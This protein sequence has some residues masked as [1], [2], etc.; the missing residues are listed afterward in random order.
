MTQP[1]FNRLT[2]PNKESV[3]HWDEKIVAE[4][5]FASVNDF[6]LFVLWESGFSSASEVLRDINETFD[7]RRI[8][9]MRISTSTRGQF[10]SRFYGT[11]RPDNYAA[12]AKEVGGSRAIAIL[13]TLQ[14]GDE[15]DVFVVA[16]AVK[17]R[18]RAG[19]PNFIHASDE[20]KE[21]LSNYVALGGEADV[22]SRIPQLEKM[23]ALVSDLGDVEPNFTL[24]PKHEPSSLSE[25]FRR[26][27]SAAD[28]VVLR[29]WEQL[30]DF[31]PDPG[32]GDIDV[33]VSDAYAAQSALLGKRVFSDS[34]RVHCLVPVAGKILGFDIRYVGDGY[35]PDRWQ[36]RMLENR[37]SR[38]LFYSLGQEDYFWTIAY[39]ALV[40][41][42]FLSEEYKEALSRIGR[43]DAYLE[44]IVTSLGGRHREKLLRKALRR[45][46]R[47]KGY[48]CPRPRDRSVH[49]FVSDS[50]ILRRVKYSVSLLFGGLGRLVHREDLSHLAIFKTYPPARSSRALKKNVFLA[51][52]YIVKRSN[53]PMFD[54]LLRNEWNQLG[55]IQ[56][57]PGFPQPVAL[58]FS[59][60][61]LYLITRVIPGRPLD[62]LVWASKADREKIMVHLKS[63]ILSLE[64]HELLHR[65]ISPS[66][67]LWDGDTL[68]VVDLEFA[69]QKRQEMAV[70]SPFEASFAATLFPGVGR[71]WREPNLAVQDWD[72][73]AL[74]NVERFVMRKKQILEILGI[75]ARRFTTT[76][77]KFS[78]R[79]SLNLRLGSM[80]VRFR[81]GIRK[82]IS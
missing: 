66:N 33:L 24:I 16:R 21:V 56:G 65:D 64:K 22:L 9:M 67:L 45:F 46:L 58:S 44:A 47:S 52:K 59:K 28:Y 2:G 15:R 81:L 51:G 34:Y 49:H 11:T 54:F 30:S 37:K 27:G 48:S 41:K 18:L 63:R 82:T 35:F 68:S 42:G 71:H 55:K 20:R 7:V 69:R 74:R 57:E 77:G 23:I 75:L 32:G 38:E 1:D 29:N 62:S 78:L 25:L 31:D 5:T 50:R 60:S 8:E 36:L 13:V 12:K 10:F 3:S 4:S 53:G 40:H 76:A 70:I 43:G 26:L 17:E 19:K 72:R 61:Q 14:E 73:S 80:L 6:C 79:E 39:H